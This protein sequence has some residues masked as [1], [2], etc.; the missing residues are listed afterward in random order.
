MSSVPDPDAIARDATWLVQA[1]DPASR[2]VRLVQMDRDSYR[3]ASFLDDRLL[4]EPRT[5]HVAPWEQVAGSLPSGARSDARWIFHI[6]HVG[7]TLIA[8]LLGEL[9]GVLSIR[10]PRTLRDV[11]V[12]PPEQRTEYT[13]A[14]PGLFSRTFD[15]A[16]TALVKATSFVSEIAAE[17]VPPAARCLFMYST[18]RAYV[19]SILAGENS[20]K[21]LQMLAAWREQRVRSRVPNLEG[22]RSSE[23]HLAAAAWACEITALQA[24][25]QGLGKE[26]VRWADF[27]D[28]LERMTTEVEDV[29]NFFGFEASPERIRQIATG[30][31]MTRYS[32]ALEYEYSP[33]LRRELLADA[34]SEHRPQIDSAMA[35]L[36]RA[37]KESPLLAAALSRTK[38]EV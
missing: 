3:Q 38:S 9:E 19:E 4:Q 1:L 27:D 18:P 7:S 25:A 30:P 28:M 26:Q 13:T 22:S 5:R 34:R 32:K 14:I 16:E 35:M 24:A 36:E 2:Q 33:A 21:E 15:P 31:L 23:A 11:A 20:R 8:R 17:I 37:A 6:G 29:S 10:E 12:L